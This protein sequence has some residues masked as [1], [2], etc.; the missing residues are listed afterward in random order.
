MKGFDLK[1]VYFIDVY[2][3]YTSIGIMHFISI[4]NI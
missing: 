1:Y 4:I 3:I 2:N